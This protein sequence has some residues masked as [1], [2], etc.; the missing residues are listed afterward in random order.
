MRPF[1][2]DEMGGNDISTTPVA[3]S[4]SA[5]ICSCTTVCRAMMPGLFNGN[6]QLTP[7]H[8]GTGFGGARGGGLHIAEWMDMLA[9]PV[10]TGRTSGAPMQYVTP[11]AAGI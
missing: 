7:L 1:E 2:P 10:R 5:G 9:P 11:A 4:G 8:G 6:P 3:L